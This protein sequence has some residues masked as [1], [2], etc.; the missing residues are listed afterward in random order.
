M[1]HVENFTRWHVS[2]TKA[3]A[4]LKDCHSPAKAAYQIAIKMLFESLLL[5][6][7]WLEDSLRI[8]YSRVAAKVFLKRVIQ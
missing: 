8:N 2:L 7:E 6:L 1:S 5:S 3:N 4:C